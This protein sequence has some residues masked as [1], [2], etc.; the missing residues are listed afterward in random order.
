MDTAADRS[1]QTASCQE[2]SD[3]VCLTGSSVPECSFA[4]CPAPLAIRVPGLVTS[5]PGS[6]RQD[7][8]SR[9]QRVD[10]F[11]ALCESVD[12]FIPSSDVCR[13]SSFCLSNPA[14]LR[15][16]TVRSKRFECVDECSSIVDARSKAVISVLVCNNP[17]CSLWQSVTCIPLPTS[18][19]FCLCT[20]RRGG[21]NLP[22]AQDDTIC[23]VTA[24]GTH[25]EE[26]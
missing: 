21:Q 5:M 25:S 24:P 2:D 22:S 13:P 20:V 1:Y 12:S 11:L 4:R 9:Q 10:G 18:L 8:R 3:H 6:S 7:C 17:S 19:R 26:D 14:F 15:S 16:S 23:A